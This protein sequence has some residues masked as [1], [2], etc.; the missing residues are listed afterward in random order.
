MQAA[1]LPKINS[2]SEPSLHPD[3]KVAVAS[4]TR[5]D[6]GADAYVGQLWRI[7]APAAAPRRLTRGFL[8]TAPDYSPDG[9]LIAFLR[10]EPDEPPQLY[11]VAGDGGEPVQV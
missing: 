5:A 7:P 1:D 8:D 2:V 11:V 6:F 10:A 4:I 9:S 3:G